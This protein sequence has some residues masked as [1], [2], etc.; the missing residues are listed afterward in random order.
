MTHRNSFKH[1]KAGK[2]TLILE[3]CVAMTFEVN[4]IEVYRYFTSEPG[5]RGRMASISVITYTLKLID[6]AETQA[7]VGSKP[8]NFKKF[9][10]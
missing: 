2:K 4:L 3:L 7:K 8:S 1:F 10:D 5:L 6:E 9:R